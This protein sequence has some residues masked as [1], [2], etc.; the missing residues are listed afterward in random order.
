MSFQ[1]KTLLSFSLVPRQKTRRCVP[2]LNTQRL[3]KKN[4]KRSVSTL[5]SLCLL[6]AMRDPAWILQKKKQ[7]KIF[8]LYVLRYSTE[9][10]AWIVKYSTEGSGR[11]GA[12]CATHYNN[13]T[14]CLGRCARAGVMRRGSGNPRHVEY[15]GL[16]I[17]TLH[18]CYRYMQHGDC[19]LFYL[20][21]I[22]FCVFNIE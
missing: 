3:E 17:A 10:V 16:R 11:E 22:L 2:P 12:G 14:T 1:L 18:L 9:K 21:I 13:D 4:Q 6:C 20:L 19:F 8:N 7:I 5:D 15:A